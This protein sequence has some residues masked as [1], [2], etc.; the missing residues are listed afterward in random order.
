MRGTGEMNETGEAGAMGHLGAMDA[1][2]RER[3][4]VRS[5]PAAMGRAGLGRPAIRPAARHGR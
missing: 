1:A 4:R 3:R 5:H 2:D